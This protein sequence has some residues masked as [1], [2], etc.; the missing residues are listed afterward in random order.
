MQQGVLHAVHAAGFFVEDQHGGVA[1]GAEDAVQEAGDA[2]TSAAPAVHQYDAAADAQEARDLHPGQRL[3]KHQRRQGH[4]NHRTAVVEQGGG[5]HADGAVSR[6]QEH[7]ACAHGRA[8]QQDQRHA[9]P[10]PGKGEPVAGEKEERQQAHAAQQRPQQHDL[11]ALQVDVAGHNAVEAEQQQPS[12]K[13]EEKATILNHEKPPVRE[14]AA[15][16]RRE[17]GQWTAMPLFGG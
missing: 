6:V 10:T 7:P 8:G 1:H 3:V 15:R 17:N 11:T 16:R 14:K 2:E 13:T 9:P 5:G 12:E 4:H